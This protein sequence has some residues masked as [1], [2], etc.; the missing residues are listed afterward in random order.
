[1][2]AIHGFVRD[3]LLLAAFILA[4]DVI[5]RVAFRYPCWIDRVSRAIY[6]AIRRRRQQLRYA[7]PRES[8]SVSSSPASRYPTPNSVNK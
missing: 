1:M 6:S 7:K 8:D 2:S 3:M 5:V 4:S